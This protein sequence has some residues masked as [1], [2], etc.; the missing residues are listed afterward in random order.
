MGRRT[1][2]Q[3][4]FLFSRDFEFHIRFFRNSDLI[5]ISS[6]REF[7]ALFPSTIDELEENKRENV[8]V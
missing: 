1:M 2:G 8:A 5:Q 3:K 6:D 7:A 4:V